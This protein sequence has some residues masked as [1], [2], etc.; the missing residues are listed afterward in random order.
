MVDI[1]NLVSG[2]IK[3]NEVLIH[4]DSVGKVRENC[5][6]AETL[7]DVPDFLL[8][9]GAAQANADGSITIYAVEGYVIRSFPVYLCYEPV[10]EENCNKVPGYYGAWSKDNGSDTLRVVD[11]KCYNLP[12]TIK[13]SLITERVPEWVM[14]SGYPISRKDET[15]ELIRTD[16]GNEV[17]TGRINKA[18]W[19]QYRKDKVNILNLNEPSAS[20][21]IV[22]YNGKDI[23]A[24][25][26]LL[27]DLINH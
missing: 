26:K 2:I 1:S 25:T 11:G 6:Y 19:V 12:T 4:K 21:Y 20:E 15:Y 13:A 3:G 10:S 8:E 17:R 24:L 18:M 14:A 9:D 7:A 5:V 22:N 23:G 16:C 27:A